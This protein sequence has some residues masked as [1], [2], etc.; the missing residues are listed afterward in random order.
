[1]GRK[2]G[3]LTVGAEGGRLV[4]TADLVG[5]TVGRAVVAAVTGAGARGLGGKVVEREVVAGAAAT[6]ESKL[7]SAAAAAVLLELAASAA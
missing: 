7:A 6:S 5:K 2:V 1:M 3:P 4:G